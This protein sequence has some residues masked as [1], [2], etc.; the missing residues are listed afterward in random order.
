M[1]CRLKIINYLVNL[2]KL[3]SLLYFL[4]F[5]NFEIKQISFNLRNPI[6]NIFQIKFDCFLTKLND[7][8]VNNF[9]IISNIKVI[10]KLYLNVLIGI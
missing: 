10:F 6:R 5:L 9:F 3:N 1:L 7:P 4:L 2:L 8:I